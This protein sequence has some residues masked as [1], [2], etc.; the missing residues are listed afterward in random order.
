MRR[1]SG[2][3]LPSVLVFSALIAYL[4]LS[5]IRD[6]RHIVRTLSAYERV[7]SHMDKEAQLLQERFLSPIM[8]IPLSIQCYDREVEGTAIK[9]CVK[10]GPAATSVAAAAFIAKGYNEELFPNVSLHSIFP[11]RLPCSGSSDTARTHTFISSHL[12]TPSVMQGGAL[13]GGN[14]ELPASLFDPSG[15]LI[16]GGQGYIKGESLRLMSHAMLIAGGD[17][18]LDDVS[19]EEVRHLTLV[20]LTSKVVLQRGDPR[21]RLRVISKGEARVPASLLSTENTLLPG[22]R[23]KDPFA[24]LTSRQMSD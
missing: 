20:S 14:L 23:V 7:R 5:I 21:I 22:T 17:I 12:C 15:I 8:P 6:G 18:E 2:Y 1:S 9:G 3:A 11:I 10:V 4:A 19:S 13:Y 16:V 24:V